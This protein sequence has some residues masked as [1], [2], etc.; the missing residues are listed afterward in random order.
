M[1]AMSMLPPSPSIGSGAGN[2]GI[3]RLNLGHSRIISR[4]DAEIFK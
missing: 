2:S 4:F 1:G 3:G